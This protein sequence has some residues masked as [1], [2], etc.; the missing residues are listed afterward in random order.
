MDFTEDIKKLGGVIESLDFIWPKQNNNADNKTK[1]IYR[2]SSYAELM[3]SSQMKR[4]TDDE[5]QYA[6]H[7][8]YNQKTS[9]ICERIFVEYGAIKATENENIRQHTDVYIEGIPFD[10]KLSVIPRNYEVKNLHLDLNKR[11]DKDVLIRWFYKNQSSEQRECFNNRIFVVCN[12]KNANQSYMLKQNFDQ[13]DVK[14][15]AFM[16]CYSRQACNI[17]ELSI[18][19][20]NGIRRNIYSD[21][22]VINPNQYDIKQ[23]LAEERCIHCGGIYRLKIVSASL[24]RGNIIMKCPRC[25]GYRNV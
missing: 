11:S 13:M 5:K 21:V 18:V 12:G 8:W 16:E 17:N 7:R 24:Y 6:L 10:I 14:I 2:I 25:R 23:K 4:L 22:I 15:R 20:R 19:D 9:E 1:F 3:S